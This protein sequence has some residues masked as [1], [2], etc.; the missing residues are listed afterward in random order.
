MDE[1]YDGRGSL[2]DLPHDQC[3][4]DE[5]AQ[6]VQYDLNHGFAELRAGRPFYAH[7]TGFRP[8]T[9]YAGNNMVSVSA[10]HLDTSHYSHADGGNEYPPTPNEYLPGPVVADSDAEIDTDAAA[11]ID[12]DAAAAAAVIEAFA[13]GVVVRVEEI[14]NGDAIVI[15]VEPAPDTARG[16]VARVTRSKTRKATEQP[17]R[18][19]TRQSLR[20][21]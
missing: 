15:N 19:R 2:C 14:A 17:E 18:P 4:C 9:Q 21:K 20:T 5:C 13:P 1:S 11:E 6:R 7:W 16:S 12:T 8:S 3:R 10:P